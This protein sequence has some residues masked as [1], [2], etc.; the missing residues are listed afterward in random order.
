MLDLSAYMRSLKFFA[1][2]FAL[3]LPTDSESVSNAS[4]K[5]NNVQGSLA[6]GLAP[7]PC[8][9]SHFLVIRYVH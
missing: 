5:D 7:E 4:L 6:L 8:L 1:L 3:P 2:Y 9:F